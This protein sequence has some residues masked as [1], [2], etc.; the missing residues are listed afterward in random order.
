MHTHPSNNITIIVIVLIFIS[1]FN[2]V[3]NK[4]YI[5]KNILKIA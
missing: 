4:Y 1:I 2:I 3:L 5:V